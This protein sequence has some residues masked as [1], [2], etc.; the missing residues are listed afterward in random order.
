M[1]V[2]AAELRR[3]WTDKTS[4]VFSTRE[5]PSNLEFPAENFEREFDFADCEHII[6]LQG[7]RTGTEDDV[8]LL[9]KG[10]GHMTLPAGVQVV[11]QSG[12]AK[13]APAGSA[14]STAGTRAPPPSRVSGYAP[15]SA[16]SGYGASYRPSTPRDAGGWE[17]VDE[18]RGYGSSR[19]NDNDS[20][21]PSES[22]SSVGSRRAGGSQYARSST[23]PF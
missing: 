11:V 15:S 6:F 18:V 13:W 21:A 17:V 8:I 16:N 12:Y 22:I 14:G 3:R 20:I 4:A 9:A 1:A 2:D 5:M 7:K 10:S 19:F 23:Q